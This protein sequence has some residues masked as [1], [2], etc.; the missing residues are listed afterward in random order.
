MKFFKSIPQIHYFV[1]LTAFCAVFLKFWEPGIGL[2]ST[3]YGA[4]AANILNGQS[5]FNF[6][7]GP[8][9][10][11]PF[12][13]HPPLIIWLQA[14]SFWL[15]GVSAQILRLPSSILGVIA[16]FCTY[17]ITRKR[18]S[19]TAGVFS[20]LALLLINPFM[21]FTSSGWLDM[22]MVGFIMLGFAVF[23]SFK[24]DRSK[25]KLALSGM[26]FAAAL[27]S[28]GLAAMGLLPIAIY[29]LCQRLRFS[30]L[31]ILA[32]SALIPIALFDGLFYSVHHR[33]FF[34]WYS[35]RR[36]TNAAEM[37]R[38]YTDKADHLWYIK[39]L[40]THSHIFFLA[41]LVGLFVFLKNR[42]SMRSGSTAIVLLCLGEIALHSLVYGFT[43]KE[44]NQYIVPTFPWIAILAG[45]GCAQLFKKADAS[46][47]A[48]RVA[49]LSLLLFIAATLI[50]T[51]IHMGEDNEVRA[52]ASTVAELKEL[53]QIRIASIPGNQHSWEGLASYASWYLQL[54][55]TLHNE[56]ALTDKLQIFEAI[57]V[58]KKVSSRQHAT[59]LAKGYSLCLT[60]DLYRLYTDQSI[61]N[62][63]R[64]SR[65]TPISDSLGSFGR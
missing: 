2:S 30:E 44:Y 31:L 18:F 41:M 13:D 49:T 25:I 1:L 5:L 57:L 3:T 9:V 58:D 32:I 17:W 11:D 16:I 10:F 15:F 12:V 51:K 14:A 64:L 21:N 48:Q 47:L 62:L 4:F 46:K 27:L 65:I 52:M 56:D 19:E 26:L 8:G 40:F 35:E 33:E 45:F 7:L 23:E 37:A 43:N 42:K 29:I 38:V 36:E 55:P 63:E 20:V 6:R 39:A 60:T 59:I 54:E 61:C 53:K 34:S 24:D 50:S 28:K 22:G